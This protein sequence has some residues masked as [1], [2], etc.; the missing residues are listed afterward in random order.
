MNKW[1]ERFLDL[2]THISQWSKDPSTK[3]GAV[4][5]R[6]NK[7]ICSV[8]YNGFPRNVDDNPE[9]LKDRARKLALTVH[10][11]TNAILNARES[12]QNYTLYVVP[13]FCCVQCASFIIQSGIVRVVTKIEI[14]KPE[15]KASNDMAKAIFTEAGV[16]YETF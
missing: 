1:D 10:A 14:D 4:I 2:A 6:P 11:E 16:S 5:V 15:W 12:L 3:V 9:I 7:T 8:G 13:L